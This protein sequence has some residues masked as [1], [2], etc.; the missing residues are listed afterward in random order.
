MTEYFPKPKSFG[1]NVKVELGLYNYAKK[2][3]LQKCNSVDTSGFVK[4]TDLAKLIS[5]VDILDI[6]K[7]I[8]YTK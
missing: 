6:D 5:D 3:R 1:K 8:K 4:K 2:S 7:L